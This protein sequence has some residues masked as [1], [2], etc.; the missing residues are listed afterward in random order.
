[1]FPDRFM[2]ADG[3]ALL[4]TTHGAQFRP[5]DGYCFRGPCKGRRLAPLQLHNDAGKL[6]LDLADE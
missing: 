4:C 3:R 2:T 5:E 6:S 1:M